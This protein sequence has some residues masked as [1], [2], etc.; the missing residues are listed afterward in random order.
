MYIQCEWT[1]KHGS[2][3][4]LELAYVTNPRISYLRYVRTIIIH[5]AEQICADTFKVELTRRS[6]AFL[7]RLL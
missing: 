7:Q 4:E 5:F 6:Y 3:S 1:L 2:R